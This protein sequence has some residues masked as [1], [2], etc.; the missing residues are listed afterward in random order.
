[1][2]M[3]SFF[4]RGVTQVQVTVET[5]KCLDFPSFL[6]TLVAVEKVESEQGIKQLEEALKK[7]LF[8]GR[9]AN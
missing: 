7:K 5:D 3:L 4:T 8:I 9:R 6:G 2:L 1:M